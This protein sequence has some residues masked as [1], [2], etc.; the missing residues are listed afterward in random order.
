MKF[1]EESDEEKGSKKSTGMSGLGCPMTGNMSNGIKNMLHHQGRRG[2]GSS[3]GSR[4]APSHQVSAVTRGVSSRGSKSRGSEG[5]KARNKRA[6]RRL[7]KKSK[8]P[9]YNDEDV[10]KHAPVIKAS[11]SR[12]LEVKGYFELGNLY[13][14][15]LF[16]MA[17]ELQGLFT[18]ERSE[19]GIKFVDM[20]AGMVAVVE[21][22]PRLHEKLEDLGPMHIRKGVQAS[23]MPQMGAV[24]FSVLQQ[25]LGEEFDARAKDAWGWVWAWLTKS[26]ALTL[27]GAGQHSSL[28]IM[29]W[30]M[31][32]DNL[33]EEELG[34]MVYETI[35]RTAPNLKAIFN[36]P[37]QVMAMK[38]I[39]MLSTVVSF[40]DDSDRM[41]EQV[42]WLG[43]RHVKYGA[44][45]HHV[46]IM[47]QVI[48]S[49]LEEAVGEEWTTEME[50]AWLDLWNSCCEAMMAAIKDAEL[51][52]SVVEDVWRNVVK[53]I[54]PERFGVTIVNHMSKLDPMVV[55]FF[56]QTFLEDKKHEDAKAPEAEGAGL[57]R[58][59]SGFGGV[60]GKGKATSSIFSKRKKEAAGT[61]GEE[62]EERMQKSKGRTHRKFNREEAELAFGTEVWG[63]LDTLITYLWEPEQMNEKLIVLGT[64]F[65]RRGIRQSHLD[66]FGE[67]IHD[68]LKSA[69][70]CPC[71]ECGKDEWKS[72]ITEAWEWLWHT[73][74]HSLMST[75][76]SSEDDHPRLAAESWAD[77][78]SRHTTEEIGEVLFSE[79]TREAPHVV[80]LF[81]RPKKLQSFMFTQAMA[82][83]VKF[84]STP[85]EFFDELRSFTIRHI[86]YGVKSEYVK[87]FGKAV[88]QGIEE[89]SGDKWT[90][91]TGNAWLS[92]WNR[93]SSCVA[94]SLNV[95]TNLIT[96]SLVNGDLDK[97][98]EAA[99]C[100][101][102]GE[103]IHWLTSVE[104]NG[105]V[106][107]PLL[108]AIRD[109][110]FAIARF[111]IQDLLAI[112]ADREC[113]YYGRERLFETHPDLVSV[114]CTDAPNLV[115]DLLDGLMW[116]SQTVL[117]GRLRV[118]YFIKDL[119]G[120]PEDI[121]D[122]WQTALAIFCLKGLPD[123]FMHPCLEKLLAMKW[124]RFGKSIFMTVQ[125]LFL[126]VTVLF[127]AASISNWCSCSM[128]WIVVRLFTG[129]LAGVM[130]IFMSYI[131]FRQMIL[132]QTAS[133]HITQT[134]QLHL[135]RLFTNPWNAVRYICLLLVVILSSLERCYIENSVD[136]CA[137]NWNG[138][139]GWEMVLKAFA[140]CMLWSQLLQ[141]LLV[142]TQLGTLTYAVGQLMF[143]VGRNLVIVAVMVLA[144]ACAL[145]A[146]Q[147]QAYD[148][149]GS[150]MVEVIR[151]V[152]RI[153]E[154]AENTESWGLVFV[155]M[156]TIT[157]HLFLFSVLIAQLV[158]GYDILFV[159]QEGNSRMN[160]A[161]QCIESESYL[162]VTT[163]KRFYDECGFDK[164]VEFDNGD[165]GP[166][167]GIQF[168]E[169]ASI[170][171]QKYYIADRIMR[172]TGTASALDPWPPT[173]EK[174][175]EN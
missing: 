157:V 133:I 137:K 105:T 151:F 115:E 159:D 46:V 92:V 90:L 171:A 75:I 132:L 126:L 40:A 78:E 97:M 102:R 31:A 71:A 91:E 57:P 17:P 51:H 50:K 172:S 30:D 34:G 22:P 60:H 139:I 94:R 124:T 53:K 101:P 138:V 76:S 147:A 25:S 143:Q 112:R 32:L 149:L 11:W 156:L 44:K 125:A 169:I 66:A 70:A 119:Y 49:V 13:Y 35:I 88:M 62:S 2:S 162:S 15:T 73:V 27:A 131:G 173:I 65:F 43:V 118:N 39:D 18:R 123:M 95:G 129:G 84:A 154:S 82:A 14:D 29:S 9:H 72:H 36:R 86:K 59:P 128:S 109:G 155:V 5:S 63:L 164:P 150:A 106:M 145:N 67:A 89:L 8:P 68:A 166:T 141:V 81:K 19:M 140:A 96:V 110:K 134:R 58:A 100:A 146:L 6:Q 21:S 103:R 77:I 108:W 37:P 98:Q 127:T 117:N 56:T 113:Y 165:E 168:M 163:R 160:R 45:Q 87:P 116:H 83:I 153:D 85:N 111:M 175:P 170:R 7:G 23:Y 52:G 174:E 152:L 114:L 41:K 48:I 107:S 20:L 28:V 24:L 161:F 136:S 158:K 148:E 144:F 104:V 64:R 122:P 167:G 130:F 16:S 47:G 42:R 74:S 93:L 38:F 3:V 33:E 54:T 142:S 69:L 120:N 99:E 55:N 135:P 26:M 80:H 61:S 79:L 12:T 4:G 10:A 1:E 121:H